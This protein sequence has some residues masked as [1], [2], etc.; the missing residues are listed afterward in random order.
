MPPPV[1]HTTRNANPNA[2]ARAAPRVAPAKCAELALRRK[3]YCVFAWAASEPGASTRLCDS[4]PGAAALSV[5]R[6]VADVAVRA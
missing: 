3:R 5:A 2:R 1:S 6:S 4:S